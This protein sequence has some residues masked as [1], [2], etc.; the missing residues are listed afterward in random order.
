MKLP[1]KNICLSLLKQ[2]RMPAMNFFKNNKL[3]KQLVFNNEEIEVI[4]NIEEDDVL[5][6]EEA[7]EEIT[8]LIVSIMENTL[9]KEYVLKHY[10][11]VL[12]EDKE[13]IYVYALDLFREK[14]GLIR[15]SVRSKVHNYIIN[16]DYI[17]ID[18]FLKFRIKEFSKYI[19]TISDRALEEFLIKKD[20]DEFVNVLKYFINMQEEKIDYIKI[21]IIDENC[22]I[23]LDKN[24]KK[25]ES[26]E[27]EEILNMVIQE[28]LNYEDFLISTLLTLCPKKIDIVDSLKNNSSKEIIETIDSIFDDRVTIL[29]L[30]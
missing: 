27:D 10:S 6:I 29:P 21:H 4:I 19:P 18:G 8:S 1:R 23:L 26:I 2:Y 28:N 11:D 24:G 5:D 15:D 30:N 14:E 7:S 13:S 22:I 20:Q 3:D 9:L 16:N 25:I 12:Y 17:N